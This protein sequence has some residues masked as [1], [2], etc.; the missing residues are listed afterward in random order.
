MS[1]DPKGVEKL[2]YLA[3]LDISEK[4]IAATTRSIGEVLALVDQL[5]QLPTGD[6]EPLSHPLDAKQRLRADR[7]TETDQRQ[8]FQTLAPLCEDGL[9][10]VPRVIE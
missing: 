8:L 9:Y 10:L 7:V 5:Q 1:I 6:I 3:R 4:D 2:A